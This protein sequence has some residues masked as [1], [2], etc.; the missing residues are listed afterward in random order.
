MFSRRTI[1]T[2]DALAELKDAV[3]RVEAD[4]AADGQTTAA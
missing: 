2:A 3:R 1:A 4:L